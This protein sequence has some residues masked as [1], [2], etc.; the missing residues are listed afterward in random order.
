MKLKGLKVIDLSVF[1]PGPQLTATLSGHGADV[2]KIEPPA[3]DPARAMQPFENGQSLWFRTLNRG[4]RSLV[5]D[6]KSAAD[7][8]RLHALVA[9]ADVFIESFRP[10]VCTRLAADYPTLSALNPGLVYCS[11]TAFGQT[12][13][14]AHHPAHDMAV[15]AFAGT[16]SVND[17]GDG[18]P[19]VPGVPAADMAASL[20]ALSAV[21]M[22]LYA[23]ERHGRGDYL[24]IAMYDSLLPLVF[25]HRWPGVGRTRT[26]A[27]DHPAFI[28]RC[29]V[30]SR[31]PDR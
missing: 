28:G 15:Q 14:L 12:G 30:L 5:L 22:A 25:A 18:H 21:M 1:L 4:K 17:G 6:L 7:Q 27:L 16:L 8:H 19:V 3:G 9:E 29:G 10:G 23:R 26:G 24:D 31:L 20:T 2:I 13:P 11:I